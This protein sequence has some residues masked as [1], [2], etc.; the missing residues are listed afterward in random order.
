MSTSDRQESPANIAETVKVF[1]IHIRATPE[2]IWTAITDPAWNARFTR[3][4]YEI[5]D[6]GNGV[7][8]LT[9][10]HDVTGAPKVTSLVAG[11]F[12]E[13]GGGW[14]QTF[15]DLKTLLETGSPLYP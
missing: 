4:T 3:V 7:C 11:D 8:A 15:S 10:S 14:A 2:A 5:T 12:P 9:L 1:R 13:F 6:E